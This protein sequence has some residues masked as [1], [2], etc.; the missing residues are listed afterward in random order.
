MV[1]LL[2]LELSDAMSVLPTCM[3]VYHMCVCCLQ[4]SEEG[5]GSPGTGVMGDCELQSM[6]DC[7]WWE[8]NSGSLQEK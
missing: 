4:R 5:V 6:G 1:L 2:F 7:G 3:C 8:L